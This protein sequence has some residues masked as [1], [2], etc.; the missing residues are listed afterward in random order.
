MDTLDGRRISSKY[1]SY[2]LQKQGNKTHIPIILNLLATIL[3]MYTTIR[4]Q[5]TRTNMGRTEL[6]LIHQQII[7][8]LKLG[9]FPENIY[10]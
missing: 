7:S 5:H 2:F 10:L 6:L 9:H 1:I 3:Y 4:Q 8:T